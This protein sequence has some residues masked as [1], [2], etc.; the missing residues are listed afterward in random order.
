MTRATR[1]PR[2]A[3]VLGGGSDIA[4]ATLRRLA[5]DGLDHA[6]LAMRQPD[7]DA[8]TIVA[9]LPGVKVSLVRWD[10]TDVDTHRSLVREAADQLGTIDVVLCAVGMLGHH[11]GLTMSPTDVD[12][13]IRTNFAGSAAALAAAAEQV[14]A[15]G[16]GTIVVLS[17]V[18]GVRPRRSNYVYGANKAGLDAFALGL[19]DAAR[20]SGVNVIVVRPG[21]V[22][23]KMTTGLPAAPFATD[24]DAVGAAI[25][26]AIAR[27]RSS[28]IWVPP[29]LGPLF[30][31]FRWLPAPV[32]RR[33]AGNR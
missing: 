33:V 11:A 2:T 8:H 12:E 20:A 28:T 6:V 31:I 32:W 14:C 26:A 3:L 15:Q 5:F 16:H 19:A 24:P 18:A 1:V 29:L 4:L 23:S 27:G 21:F 9:A 10:A 25:A 13:M 17:S 22:R 30:T 7:R